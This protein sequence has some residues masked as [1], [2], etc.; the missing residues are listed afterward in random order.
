MPTE[1]IKKV[2]TVLNVATDALIAHFTEP[3]LAQSQPQFYKAEQK[4]EAA[5]RQSFADAV[6]N[7]G[8]SPDQQ[9][10]LLKL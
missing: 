10:N 3:M 6:R 1:F 4:P 9:H 5:T 2:A 8:L 7:S